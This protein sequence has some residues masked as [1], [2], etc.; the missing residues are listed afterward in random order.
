[1]IESLIIGLYEYIPLFGEIM[2]I[3]LES[4]HLSLAVYIG[5]QRYETIK[6]S[7]YLDAQ[8]YRIWTWKYFRCWH[9]SLAVYIGIQRY[10]TI[11]LSM[12]LN[13]QPYRIWTWKYFRCWTLRNL[14]LK[15][16]IILAYVI[17]YTSTN[18]YV[19][20]Q[21]C[22]Y[23]HV[24]VYWSTYVFIQIQLIWRYFE[25]VHSFSCK[26]IQ[27]YTSI[28]RYFAVQTVHAS[29]YQFWKGWRILRV[30]RSISCILSSISYRCTTSVNTLKC[31][32]HSQKHCSERTA[33]QKHPRNKSSAKAAWAVLESRNSV[34]NDE[35]SLRARCENLLT[36][37]QK[38]LVANR[39]L[40]GE[41]QGPLNNMS[42][43]KLHTMEIDK[44]T[45]LGSMSNL[46]L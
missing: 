24:R 2:S 35:T 16:K 38:D 12:Y 22:M 17:V 18:L 14:D 4:L 46:H 32:G 42:K 41:D 44:H 37:P 5:I 34:C 29:K 3:P 43:A 26:Y 33:I 9:L 36:N 8:P 28:C 21:N 31:I 30:K 25:H 10:E 6:L 13:A 15:I 45:D 7:M 11:K 27:V 23:K 20:S 39:E 1:M 19:L 40:K